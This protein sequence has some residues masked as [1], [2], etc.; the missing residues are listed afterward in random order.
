MNIRLHLYKYIQK[1]INKFRKQ[2]MQQNIYNELQTV[3][4]L[5]DSFVIAI[6]GNWGTGKTFF[7]N[8]FKEENL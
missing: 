3:F 8:K 1:L 5:Y 4:K 7:W 2:K 6:K